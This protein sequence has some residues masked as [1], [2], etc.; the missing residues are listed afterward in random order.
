MTK[1]DSVPVPDPP[2]P[3]GLVGYVVVLRLPLLLWLPLLLVLAVLY[4]C[5]EWRRLS[6]L[7]RV[8][9]VP[10]GFFV[11]LVLLTY[12]FVEG[13]I[14][15]AGYVDQSPIGFQP[16]TVRVSSQTLDVR[17][18]L[19]I[20]ELELEGLKPVSVV[21]SVAGLGSV[22]AHLVGHSIVI[23]FPEG[24][25]D[26]L[27]RVASHNSTV[28]LSQPPAA[29]TQSIHVNCTIGLDR[30]VL[31]GSYTGFFTWKE[32]R[33]IARGC[34]VVLANEN[35]VGLNVTIEAL[36]ERGPETLLVH[37][38]VMWVAPFSNYTIDLSSVCH[39]RCLV[40]ISYIFLGVPRTQVV[41]V[42]GCVGG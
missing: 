27:W 15:G 38:S 42:H 9:S 33:L 26:R 40:R 5:L 20:V 18:G 31:Q 2:V 7:S 37:H 25:F 17:K 32:P 22:D 28:I 30:G 16:P 10:P 1:G 19:F 29:V 12:L 35:P 24:F 3:R 14:V 39:Q 36:E 23:V 8:A 41:E 34:R 6:Q 11:L 13:V 21:C 4:I